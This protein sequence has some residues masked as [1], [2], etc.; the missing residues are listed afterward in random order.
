MRFPIQLSSFL[1][2]AALVAQQEFVVPA[3]FAVDDAPAMRWAAGFTTA[4]RQQVLIA[5]RHLIAL[6]GRTITA[7]SV[8]RDAAIA[9]ALP[10]GDADLVLQLSTSPRTP[11][12]PA[13]ELAKNVGAD[14]VTVQAGRVSIPSS[15]AVAGTSVPWDAAHAVRFVFQQPFVYGGGTLCVDLRGSPAPGSALRAW[16]VD[17]VAGAARGTKT[18]LGSSCAAVVG[19]AGPAGTLSTTTVDPGRLVVGA[20]ARF[21]AR[22]TPGTA[23]AM[24]VGLAPLASPIELRVLGAPGCFVHV[25][26]IASLSATFGG[27]LSPQHRVLGGFADAAL[28][29]PNDNGLRGAGFY[30]QWLQLGPPLATSEA[31]RCTI[32]AAAPTLGMA[33]VE[34]LEGGV[35]PPTHGR[36]D[37]DQGL[38]MRFE[39]R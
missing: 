2:P 37:V 4:L 30:T 35:A 8:R 7:L 31:L 20:S 12:D 15:P 3:E 13:E 24:V 5:D 36:V 28:R 21:V 34:A 19:V 17:A 10:G 32:A 16:P 26:G 11:E 9:R 33:I 1:L 18:P 29:I 6:R 27:E 25:H 22:G 38:V 39:A 23:A 14:A